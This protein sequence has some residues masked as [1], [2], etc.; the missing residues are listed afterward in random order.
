MDGIEKRA[1]FCE[2]AQ[3]ISA[4]KKNVDHASKLCSIT[5]VVSKQTAEPLA[6][7]NLAHRLANFLTRINQLVVQSLV[8]SLCV[9]RG[10]GQL[11][12]GVNS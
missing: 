7:L 5:I 12:D 6:A 9:I 11:G 3:T 10:W 1:G 4:T 8:V 2:S